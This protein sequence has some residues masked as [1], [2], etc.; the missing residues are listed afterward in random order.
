MFFILRGTWVSFA[1]KSRAELSQIT[2]GLLLS[3]IPFP[4]S[5]DYFSSGQQNRAQ[6]D[7]QVHST[8]HP[9]GLESSSAYTA[10]YSEAAAS[11]DRPLVESIS[12]DLLILSLRTRFL[13]T[14][15]LI[16]N[17]ELRSRR[18][19]KETIGVHGKYTLSL[20]QFSSIPCIL[21]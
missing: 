16:E 7:P 8:R 5:K 14:A 2:A 18:V 19:E 13:M 20:R 6:W 15:F 1:S 10:H 3:L 17:G 9:P 11:V 12:A 4:S 21:N